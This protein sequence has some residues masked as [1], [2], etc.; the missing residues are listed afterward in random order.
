I[1]KYFGRCRSTEK[2]QCFRWQHCLSTLALKNTFHWQLFTVTAIARGRS[3]NISVGNKAQYTRQENAFHWQVFSVAA[4]VRGWSGNVSSGN[5]A[6]PHP[7]T[8]K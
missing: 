4:M 5:N 1:G 6:C 3:G 8:R 2:W 7:F